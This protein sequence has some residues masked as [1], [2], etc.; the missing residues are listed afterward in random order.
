MP[1]L[2]RAARTGQ[3]PP[4]GAAAQAT[5]PAAPSADAPAAGPIPDRAGEP[6]T[7][8]IPVVTPD[9]AGVSRPDLAGASR[10]DLAVDAPA[11]P[12]V[13]VGSR[14]TADGIPKLSRRRDYR[15]LGGVAG[16]IADHLRVRVLWVRVAFVLL[17]LM[18]GAGVL[19]YGLLWIFVPQ[20]SPDA[21]APEPPSPVERRQALGIAAVG[22][23][24]LI[25]VAALGLGDSL[26][27][28]LGPLGLAAIGAAFIWREADDARRARWRRSA[29]GIVGPSRASW[30]RLIG[31]CVLVVGG[32]SVF[33]LGQVDFTAVQSA[34]L[35]VVLTLVGVAVI[36]IPWWV[37]LVRD[38]GDER[39]GRIREKERAEIAAHLH[40][41]V[42]QTLAL[43]QR[44]A[45]DSKE[46]L[47]LARSQERQLRTWLYGPAGYAA[48]HGT[49]DSPAP[50]D[51]TFAA[52][53]A[54]AAGEVE[55]TYNLAVTPVIVG[56]AGMDQHLNALVAASREAMVNAAK[57]AQVEEVS[58]YAE[59][60]DG[61]ASVFV[62]DRGIGFDQSVVGSDRRGLAESIRG[63]M[64][65]HGGTATV[66]SAP[67]DGTEIELTMPVRD[68]ETG[69]EPA[70]AASQRQGDVSS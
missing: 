28:V 13:P 67:G 29:A 50:V 39:Q 22:V 17:A 62:R 35:A 4:E 49:A 34:L 27:V 14:Y 25:V 11:S 55:D 21:P 48:G 20:A 8:P 1:A 10:P 44:Q 30:W 18:G 69:A 53:L 60:E 24:I 70:P 61:T 57:H 16:G 32:L 26:G 33:A 3:R 5:D 68:R 56:D 12:R 52:S 65:R 66:R 37:R 19:A 15:V 59:I 43:I 63:R 6:A 64:E 9:P 45:G 54:E 51:Q 58:V 46:V 40:D 2:R 38:L 7:Q 23:A 47:R 36:T 42:L 41:S 31:G